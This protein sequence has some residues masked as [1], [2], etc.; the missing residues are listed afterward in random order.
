MADPPA[1]SEP[2]RDWCAAIGVPGPIELGY[3]YLMLAAD[4]AAG[5]TAANQ[6]YAAR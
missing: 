2:E 6:A 5:P 4:I 1:E 3:A